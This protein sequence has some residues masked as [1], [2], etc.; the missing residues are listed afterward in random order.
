[1]RPLQEIFPGEGYPALLVGLGA[2][3][4]A[5]AWRL[6]DLRALVVTTDFFTPVVD[7]PYDYGAIAAANALSD[8]YAMGATPFMALN[9]AAIPTDLEP[10]VIRQIFLGGAEKIREAGAVLAGG[11][12][13]QDKEPKFGFVALGMVELARM[14]TK[15]EARPGD[16]LIMTKPLG[17][18][19]VTTALKRGEAEQ[20]HV[21]EAVRWMKRLN[22]PAGALATEFGLRAATDVTG[23]GLLGHGV[24]MAEASGVRLRLHF[25]SVPFYPFA[26]QYAQ[27]G[28]FPD[29]SFDNQRYFG[30][31]VAF[32]PMIDEFDKM[33][34]FDAQTSGGLLLAAP[35]EEVEG[36]HRAASDASVSAW[37]IGEVEEG[38]G[39]HVVDE[40]YP[41]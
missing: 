2:P 31:K 37:T 12:S 15:A 24:E 41:M 30:P 17:T 16:V 10:E 33:L 21:E 9:I 18:G 32:D 34:L 11:H 6:D 7:D 1:M 13:V 14:M 35:K 8:V 27:K 22:G 40:A 4:D 39:V 5:A 25:H 29:G 3:D 28:T 36:F 23:Y 20:A 38:E 26:R 19:V